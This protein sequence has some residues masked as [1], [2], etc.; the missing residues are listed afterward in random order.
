ME[1]KVELKMSSFTLV[2]EDEVIQII[3]KSSPQDPI[4]TTLLKICL[5]V[6]LKSTTAIINKSL[7]NAMV[8]EI[9]KHAIAKQTC[10]YLSKL[11]ERVVNQ[12]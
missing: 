6:L 10:L 5:D 7:D 12:C 3:T 1:L 4:P 9:L 8:P 2:T 11:I